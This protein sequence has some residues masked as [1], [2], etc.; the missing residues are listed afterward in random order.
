MQTFPDDCLKQQE[1]ART[2]NST[3]YSRE[4]S[5]YK[6]GSRGNVVTQVYRGVEKSESR[7]AHNLENVGAEPTSA[8]ISV[9]W[10]FQLNYDRQIK[11]SD[12]SLCANAIQEAK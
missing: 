1:F 12:M 3:R 4:N 9:K 6:K 10:I 11:L 2:Y 7:H 5:G 8:T